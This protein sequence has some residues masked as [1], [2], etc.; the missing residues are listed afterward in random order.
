MNPSHHMDAIGVDAERK[1]APVQRLP[2][3]ECCGR[4]TG[5]LEHIGN[6]AGVAWWF[7]EYCNMEIAMTIPHALRSRNM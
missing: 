3:R 2:R 5:A 7:C 6:F 4:C 1:P